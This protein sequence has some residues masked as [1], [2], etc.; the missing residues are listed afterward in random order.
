MNAQ[1]GSN[2]PRRM[3]VRA[4]VLGSF[5]ALAG[6]GFGGWMSALAALCG[7]LAA[8]G[9]S[10]GYMKSHVDSA[11]TRTKALDPG[12]LR[13]ASLRFVGVFL[14]GV[15]FFIAGRQPVMSYLASFAVC[16]AILVG[17]EV[18]RA[19]RQLKSRR[20]G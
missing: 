2:S 1:S 13:A 18:P 8:G 12:V 3:L 6:L 4:L 10:A 11:G 15:S 17:L 16:F 19:T 7:A 20:I 5:A 9:Y 14:L